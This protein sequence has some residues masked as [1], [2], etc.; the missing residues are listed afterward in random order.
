MNLPWESKEWDW[1]I[2]EGISYLYFCYGSFMVSKENKVVLLGAMV[3]GLSIALL[4]LFG[5]R[6]EI[7]ALIGIVIGTIFS[8]LFSKVV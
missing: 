1:I 4:N 6:L 8:V 3:I 5:L 2:G 7:S